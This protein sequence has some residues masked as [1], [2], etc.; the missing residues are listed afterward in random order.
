M[1]KEFLYIILFSFCAAPVAAQKDFHKLYDYN[2]QSDFGNRIIETDSG[3]M[4]FGVSASVFDKFLH[5]N[6]LG[7]IIYN[8]H[9]T[10]KN[11]DLHGG[12]KWNNGY[13]G[14][15]SHYDPIEGA[16]DSHF[17][18]V[19]ELGDSIKVIK[20]DF[21][22]NDR[23]HD[24][25]LLKDSTFVVL[26]FYTDT[27][28]TESKPFVANVDSLG[29]VLWMETHADSTLPQFIKNIAAT[30]DGGYI[31]GG[32]EYESPRG[33][34]DLFLIKVDSVGKLQWKK[35]YGLAN[36]SESSG[37]VTVCKNGGYAIAGNIVT[38]RGFVGDG[39]RGLRRV[40]SSGNLLWEKKF[41]TTTYH[42]QFTVARELPNGDFIC[43]GSSFHT[44]NN[45][46]I[47]DLN[48]TRLDSA[49]NLL[50]SKD[51][52]YHGQHSHDY[53]KDLQIT[54]DS[55]FIMTG[56]II[57]NLLPSRNDLFILKVND[58]GII[59]SINSGFKEVPAAW[60]IYPNPT[61]GNITIPEI[62][63]LDKIEV[64]NLQGQKVQEQLPNQSGETQ[65]HLNGPSGIYLIH[66]QKTDGS[67]ESAK[68]VKQ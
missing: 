33:W 18:Y 14:Y 34:L 31:I 24:A 16:A 22:F 65:L 6:S 57:N 29:T 9:Y 38:I 19:N 23:I 53:V 13:Y 43:A 59:T 25:I 27:A 42:E 40:D 60:R 35:T 21:A 32:E 26:G 67:V 7:N 41:G 36:K 62:S 8:K 37:H 52:T 4:V 10:I 54:S 66:L 63:N 20:I 51:Y 46:D 30:Q 50:W 11:D 2:N 55:G 28:A 3:F 64:F 5:V 58:Q 15:G 17:M 44:Y 61:Q 49:G 1:K 45:Q 56:F 47:P 12:G 48:I 68:V 39:D